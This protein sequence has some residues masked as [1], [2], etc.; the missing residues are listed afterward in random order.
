[1]IRETARSLNTL[2]TIPTLTTEEN[3]ILHGAIRGFTKRMASVMNRRGIEVV[4]LVSV[5]WQETLR[6]RQTFD[7]GRGCQLNTYLGK[8]LRGVFQTYVERGSKSQDKQGVRFSEMSE[9]KIDFECPNSKRDLT[10]YE[11]LATLEG[12]E[13]EIVKLLA[14]GYT[15]T[16]I[17]ELWNM[18]R[19]R[20]RQLVVRIRYKI[21][22]ML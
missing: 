11:I 2:P 5:G 3:A 8:C 17:A 7:P 14:E 18:S 1:M 21:K 20:V 19:E 12:R 16:Q 9:K 22:D 6:V 10:I 13:K 15:Y 4:E